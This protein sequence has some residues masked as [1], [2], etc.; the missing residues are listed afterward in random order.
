MVNKGKLYCHDIKSEYKLV[1][2]PEKRMY[3]M[4]AVHDQLGHRGIYTMKML[5][6]REILVA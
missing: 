6:K 1:I 5:I 4:K 3:I 2:Y